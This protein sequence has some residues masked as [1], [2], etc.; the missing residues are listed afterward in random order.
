MP[1]PAEEPQPGTQT[2]QRA[3]RAAER[4]ALDRRTDR[5]LSDL[6][7]VPAS[8]ACASGMALVQVLSKLVR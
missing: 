1:G 4:A 5:L 3:R 2:D 8:L 7:Q 6:D